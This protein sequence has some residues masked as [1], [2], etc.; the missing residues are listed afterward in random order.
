[1]TTHHLDGA[2]LACIHLTPRIKHRITELAPG[3]QL[4]IDTDDPAAREGIPSWCRLT[5]N[6]LLDTVE[7]DANHSTFTIQ[8]K[9]DP[10]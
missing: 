4:V 10:S 5:H 1:M 3:D 7:H 2:G 8:K 6:P 9:E